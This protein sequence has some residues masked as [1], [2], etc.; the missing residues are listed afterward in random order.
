MQNKQVVHRLGPISR[1][2]IT[3]VSLKVDLAT[4]EMRDKQHK[5]LGRKA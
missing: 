2:T 1:Q 4:E 5:A 3:K